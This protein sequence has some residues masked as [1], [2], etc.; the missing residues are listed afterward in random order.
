[1]GKVEGKEV[2]KVVVPPKQRLIS[3]LLKLVGAPAAA[4]SAD[5]AK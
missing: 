3:L 1:M 2:E 5:S 4:R